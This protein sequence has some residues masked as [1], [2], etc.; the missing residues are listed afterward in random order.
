ME[1]ESLETAR[2]EAAALRRSQSIQRD[3]PPRSARAVDPA[4]R[5]P[6]LRL[7]PV[8]ARPD[9]ESRG[10]TA[11]PGSIAAES[12]RMERLVGD[13]LDRPRS[14][15][16]C[17]G[18]SATGVTWRWSPAPRRTAC[19]GGPVVRVRVTGGLE[20]VWADHDR[21]EQVFVNLLENAASHGASP[22]GT[23][24][25]VRA[26]GA[27][28]WPGWRSPMT[29]RASRPGW[30]RRSSSHG[31][32][33]PPRWRGPGWDCPS[34]GIVEAHGDT[35]LAAPADPGRPS[36]SRSRQIR[37]QEPPKSR[38]GHPGTWWRNRRDNVVATRRSSSS[39]RTTRTSLTWSGPTS[40]PAATT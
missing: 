18:C 19:P 22:R 3:N 2:R 36:W 1:R 23:D 25:T 40:P 39:W 4:D 32:G 28:G 12:A 27:L 6:R 29:G 37:H 10:D 21:P 7:H 30:L 17:C 14:N 15:R 26:G 33:A 35:L 11:V 13:L 31:S 24:V 20:P 38:P 5:H 9:L 8:P 34:H 16:A